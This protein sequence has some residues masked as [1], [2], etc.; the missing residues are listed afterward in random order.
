MTDEHLIA[1]LVGVVGHVPP[2]SDAELGR[3]TKLDVDIARDLTGL[4]RCTHLETL[5][6]FAS[7]GDSIEPL[8][9]MPSLTSLKIGC[10]G[11]R[12]LSPLIELP[13]LRELTVNFT[14]V[15]DATPILAMKALRRVEL[16]GN[17]FDPAS[18]QRLAASSDMEVVLSPKSHW[19]LTR[20]LFDAGLRV[21]YGN[22]PGG[23]PALVVN[24][25]GIDFQADYVETS[26]AVVEKQLEAKRG[27]EPEMFLAGLTIT[28]P[29]MKPIDYLLG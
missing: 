20:K 4:E 8:R 6:F 3:V 24:E 1:A 11:V 16:I 7:F 21:A 18:Y 28:E 10:V 14:L 19:E 22:R 13:N 15:T 12:D 5:R 2:F 23:R 27:E 9:R 17:P 29:S 26:E 25:Q